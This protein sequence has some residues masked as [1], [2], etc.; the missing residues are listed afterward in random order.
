MWYYELSEGEFYQAICKNETDK[1]NQ[2][3]INN[4]VYNLVIQVTLSQ[5]YYC[6]RQYLL[7]DSMVSKSSLC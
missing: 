6:H 4:D 1:S 3:I 5:V 7:R 2:L